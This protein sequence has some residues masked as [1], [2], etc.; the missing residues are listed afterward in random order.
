MDEHRYGYLSGRKC[1]G[2]AIEPLHYRLTELQ[3]LAKTLGISTSRKNKDQL[4]AEI[5]QHYS[6]IKKTT[7]PSVSTSK[8]LPPLPK[9]KS[10]SKTSDT[11]AVPAPVSDKITSPAPTLAPAAPAVSD[12][13]AAPAVSDKA[14]P[15]ASTLM[16]DRGFY[17]ETTNPR[18]FIRRI[19][20][21]EV[22][23][24]IP[25]LIFNLER[26]LGDRVDNS[27]I[28]PEEFIQLEQVN[29][30]YVA[31]V[32]RH[33]EVSGGHYIT[34]FQC[35]GIW[36]KYDDT[37][38]N[39]SHIGTYDQLIENTDV[40]T[41]GVLH[42]Y[43]DETKEE[44][45]RKQDC[46]RNGMTYFTNS[47]Y[48]DSTLFALFSMDNPI[49]LEALFNNPI[50]DEKQCPQ[51]IKELIRE[52]LINLHKYFRGM[53]DVRPTCKNLRKLFSNCKLTPIYEDFSTGDQR[54]ASEFIM[55]LFRLFGVESNKSKVFTWG[56]DDLTVNSSCLFPEEGE[57]CSPDDV[58][59]FTATS[60]NR[61]MF[62]YIF[63]ITPFKIAEYDG[64]TTVELLADVED[65]VL[66]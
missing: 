57:Q 9:S 15:A 34:Y 54:S 40:A 61:E 58:K 29:L 11:Q 12:K 41:L 27:S 13:A 3:L 66:L 45:R 51:R 2:T 4:C 10:P 1:E 22:D 31:S 17:D 43:T 62:N 26:N 36:Y 49:L 24:D 23:P 32:V 8:K 52:E 37:A 53:T 7:S 39:I 63:N 33:G 38:K 47:C 25:F 19:Q 28:L 30:M 6:T 35:D 14:A 46:D 42:F 44:L 21:K 56:T 60:V 20:Y 16:K 48:M 55:Y 59:K 64:L 50:K 65:L 18:G 5:R